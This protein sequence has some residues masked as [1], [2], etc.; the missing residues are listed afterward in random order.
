MNK[1]ELFELEKEYVT[2]QVNRQIEYLKQDNEYENSH[3]YDFYKIKRPKLVKKF[4]NTEIYFSEEEYSTYIF[5]DNKLLCTITDDVTKHLLS[6]EETRRKFEQYTT[7]K[8]YE[9]YK[10]N[11]NRKVSL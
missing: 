9:K 6:K 4:D 1:K 2:I 5:V 7:S 10:K 3:I 8:E 11:V